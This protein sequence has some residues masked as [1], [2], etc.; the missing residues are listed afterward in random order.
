MVATIIPFV[1]FPVTEIP[2]VLG[3]QAITLFS[4]LFGHHSGMVLHVVYGDTEQQAD[5][6]PGK[7]YR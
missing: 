7:V 3:H 6:S 5:E 4:A 1:L 2:S